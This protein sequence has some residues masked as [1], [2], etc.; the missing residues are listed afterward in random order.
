[1]NNKRWTLKGKLALIT[2]GTRGI[3]QGIVD[4]F[5]NLGA[6]VI[7]VSRTL[8][9]DTV[10]IES[11]ESMEADVSTDE[12]RKKL[13]DY[14]FSN[15]NKLDILVN[16]VGTNIRKSTSEYSDDELNFL[17]ET[18]LKSTFILSKEF[19]P[20]LK[21]SG[22]GSV[23]N[24]SS[25]AGLTHVRTGSIYGM[26]KGAINQL[27][28]NLAGE[29]GPDNIRVNAIAPWY[30]ST[31][32]VESVLSD[33]SY[34]QE[35]LSRTPM[36]RVGEVKEVSSLAAFLC[37]PAASYITGQVITVDGGFSIYGF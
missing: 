21:E 16:N 5:L 2:G 34:M 11:L 4:E 36:G 25:V 7:R 8:D 14:I 12:G 3:G 33:E 30:I 26:T 18:N 6:N 29:W 17:I 28:Q 15:H 9:E 22:S 1:M 20:L 31:P 13:V 27:T 24:I 10:D 19:Y 35:V 37:M 32:L 23:V